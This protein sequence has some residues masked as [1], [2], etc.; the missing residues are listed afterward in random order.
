MKIAIAVVVDV[1]FSNALLLAQHNELI[2]F[3]ILAENLD[4]LEMLNR[5]KSPI[6]DAEIKG[7]LK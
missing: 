1:W 4:I 5:K 3:D 7:F 6:E 2:Y